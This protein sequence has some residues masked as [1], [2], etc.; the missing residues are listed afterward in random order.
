MDHI[1]SHMSERITGKNIAGAV[2]VSLSDL[3]R[4]FKQELGVSISDYIRARR[5][6][7]AK[8]LLRHSD[9]SIKKIAD[10]LPG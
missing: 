5:L 10:R 6:D 8:N 3:S 9:A 7:M 4:T 1:F 2:K